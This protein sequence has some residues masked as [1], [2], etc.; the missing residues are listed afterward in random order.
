MNGHATD[1]PASGLVITG[2]S[3]HDVRFPTSLTGDGT[4]AMNKTCDY[5]AAYLILYT[6]PKSAISKDGEP[7]KT[8]S[9]AV[10]QGA[11]PLKGYG[12]T[13]TIGRGNEVSAAAYDLRKLL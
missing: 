3:V 10:K 2:Y 7:V 6:G 1:L 9:V 4:D 5:S 8:D 12:M 11:E 13:F